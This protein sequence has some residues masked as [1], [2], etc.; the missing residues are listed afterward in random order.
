MATSSGPPA[1]V[2]AL[3]AASALPSDSTRTFNSS[4]LFS[5]R[6][7]HVCPD[8]RPT[9]VRTRGDVDQHLFEIVEHGRQCGVAIRRG[10]LA[11]E[12]VVGDEFLGARPLRREIRRDRPGRRSTSSTSINCERSRCSPRSDSRMRSR[13]RLGRGRR[14][15]RPWLTGGC[16][17]RHPAS[18][19]RRGHEHA[20][21]PRPRPA[22][23]ARARTTTASPC[24][25]RARVP[26]AAAPRPSARSRRR[27]RP[28][29][30]I[31][32]PPA[33]AVAS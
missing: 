26:A 24:A 4:P 29:A 14:S 25:V 13:R 21:C 8:P 20:Q 2:S 18:E 19:E 15:R 22:A 30:W 27:L 31:P 12:T 16:C 23:P 17:L 1:I 32:P 5:I 28:A 33:R 9:R 11:I 6:L 3:S 7:P 10:G